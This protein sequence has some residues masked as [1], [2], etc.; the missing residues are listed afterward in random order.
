MCVLKNL[1][2]LSLN[3]NKISIIPREIGYLTSLTQLNLS[4]VYSLF[5]LIKII[6]QHK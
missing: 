4:D 2:V 3:N 1:T 6:N 5:T